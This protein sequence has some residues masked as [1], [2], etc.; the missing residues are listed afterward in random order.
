VRSLHVE[1]SGGEGGVPKVAIEVMK[2][3]AKRSKR[4]PPWMWRCIAQALGVD[5]K[6]RSRAVAAA[7]AAAAADRFQ[8]PP[9]AFA[10]DMLTIASAIIMLVFLIWFTGYDIAS[11]RSNVD[12][13]DGL[14]VVVMC[15]LFAALGIYAHRLAT[16]L[17]IHPKILDMMR[18]H[19]KTVAKLNV[20]VLVFLMMAMFIVAVN[21]KLSNFMYFQVDKSSS[22]APA[23]NNV[24]VSAEGGFPPGGGN[25]K[26][27]PLINDNN[28]V[29]PCQ[30]IA[31][32]LWICQTYFLSQVV[33]SLFFLL[34]NGVVAMVLV[35]VARTH[36]VSIRRLICQLDCDAYLIDQQLR[37]KQSNTSS[38]ENLYHYLWA[39]NSVLR[40]ALLRMEATNDERGANIGRGGKNRESATTSSNASSSCS[41]ESAADAASDSMTEEQCQE[42]ADQLEIHDEEPATFYAVN[43][44]GQTV[45][46]RLH[47]ELRDN[48]DA[49]ATSTSLTRRVLSRAFNRFRKLSEDNDVTDS[50]GEDE[51]GDGGGADDV[52]DDG[53]EDEEDFEPH[54]MTTDEILHKHWKL[55]TSTRLTSQAMQRWMCSMTTI[56]LFYTAIQIVYWLS[57]VPTLTGVLS[58]ICPLLLLPLLASAYAE[59]NYEG[60]NLLQSIMPSEERTAM[61]RYLYGMPVQLT[62]YGRP[63]TY[64]TMSTVFA[65]ILAAFASKILLKSMNA[66]LD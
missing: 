23:V 47:L 56:I 51:R 9:L 8:K 14:T 61:F 28:T 29:N 42:N 18:L 4:L 37:K 65:A 41:V 48:D 32:P 30:T 20:S 63:V 21:V 55:V 57:H 16:R 39:G 59:V 26:P 5:A 46:H 2:A 7:S 36:T 34:W 15:F 22:D 10:L 45:G 38:K 60:L 12:I 52:I 6:P 24:T 13:L 25:K 35:S 19:S 40:K 31:I 3:K 33:F 58:F 49:A 62:L 64:A 11:T 43:S 17:F 66:V 27:N 53:D 44:Q 1:E 50:R 54:I